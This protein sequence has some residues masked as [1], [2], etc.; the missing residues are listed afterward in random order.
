[1]LERNEVLQ[2]LQEFVEIIA[3]VHA[4]DGGGTLDGF[5]ELLRRAERHVS[6]SWR[7]S[8]M[9]TPCEEMRAKRSISESR[10]LPGY[11]EGG[12]EALE[13]LEPRAMHVRVG[14]R[15]G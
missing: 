4:R 10:I 8:P 6:D 9:G 15:D 11:V 12:K 1:M 3:H 2:G 13:E 7:S 5:D 14:E